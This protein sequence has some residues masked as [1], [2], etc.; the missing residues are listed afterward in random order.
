MDTE[1][2]AAHVLEN[3]AAL[4]AETMA[5]TLLITTLASRM[6]RESRDPENAIMTLTAPVRAAAQEFD[7]SD[8]ESLAAFEALQAMADQIESVALAQLR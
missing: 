7:G 4:R 3:I 8:P 1:D 6:A 2:F 5:H